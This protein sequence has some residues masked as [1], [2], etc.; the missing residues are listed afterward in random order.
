MV[1]SSSY[2]A[3]YGTA[4]LRAALHRR[5]AR[6]SREPQGRVAG[7]IVV[8]DTIPL[9]YLILIEAAQVLPALFDRDAPSAVIQELSDRR[10][11]E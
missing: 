7:V 1:S 4:R 9:N 5:E 10:G 8:S 3:G 2:I 11:P 6:S